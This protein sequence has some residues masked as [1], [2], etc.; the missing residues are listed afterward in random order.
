MNKL[1]AYYLV[2]KSPT[3]LGLFSI[4]RIEEKMG[5]LDEKVAIVTGANSWMDI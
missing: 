3:V 2:T 1:I 5:I 4:K